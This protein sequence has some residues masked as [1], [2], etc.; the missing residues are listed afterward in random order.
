M[1][2]ESMW[3]VFLSRRGIGVLMDEIIKQI[4][5]DSDGFVPVVVQDYRDN[6][7][8]MVAYMNADSLSMT[9]KTGNATYWSRS[10][11]KLWTK[12]ETSGNLQK[13]KELYIDCDADCLLIKVEQLGIAACHTGYRSCFYRKISENKILIEEKRFFNPDE[14]Y[15]A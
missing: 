10:R 13:V 7:V 5:F 11:K 3:T 14:K 4:K 1:A 8:L 9:L 12:G 2:L 6:R 15:I